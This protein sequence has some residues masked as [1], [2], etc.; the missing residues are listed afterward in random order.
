MIVFFNHSL[1]PNDFDIDDDLND[2][3]ELSTILFQ[4]VSMLQPLMTIKLLRMQDISY[5]LGFIVFK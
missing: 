4:D 5:I 1:R 3:E 2:H